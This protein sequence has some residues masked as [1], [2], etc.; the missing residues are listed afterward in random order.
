MRKK[1]AHCSNARGPSRLTFISSLRL[2]EGA[3]GVAMGDDRVG[4][5]RPEAGDARKQRRRGG[6]EIDADRVDRVL[7]H[8]L[9]RTAEAMLVDVVLILPDAD[10]LRLDLDEFGER[11]LQAPRDRHRAAQRNVEVGKFGRRERRGR[12]D[13]GAGFADDNLG[14]LLAAA[15]LRA[16]RRPAARSRGSPCRCRSRSARSCGA[17]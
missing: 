7:D 17:R 15:A 14:R 6:V 8:R 2:G 4:E 1:P 13:R 5:R 16:F 11:V 3:V 10:R 9:E 12:I